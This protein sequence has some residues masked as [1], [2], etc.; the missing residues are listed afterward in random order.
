MRELLGTAIEFCS[1]YQT[2][3]DLMYPGC[4]RR[5]SSILTFCFKL[6]LQERISIF[7]IYIYTW[8][9]CSRVSHQRRIHLA[10]KGWSVFQNVLYFLRISQRRKCIF[11][12]RL[13]ISIMYL[14]HNV[15]IESE[16]FFGKEQ[17]TVE[18]SRNLLKMSIL[19]IWNTLSGLAFDF[20]PRL[21]SSGPSHHR[22][23]TCRHANRCRGNCPPRSR[24]HVSETGT[25]TWYVA[26]NN[27]VP[28]G[29]VTCGVRTG[30]HQ[31][32]SPDSCPWRLRLLSCQSQTNQLTN[33]EMS[34][35]NRLSLTAYEAYDYEHRAMAGKW[36]VML[37][38][39]R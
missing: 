6:S 34:N 18:R 25:T 11:T 13:N 32:S 15:C 21:N 36:G 26:C 3:D 33:P 27:P 20:E 14:N 30:H 39:F 23:S 2:F 1:A 22:F 12:C 24:S 5:S 35:V 9:K 17:G 19:I 29:T 4:L 37:Q 7:W 16:H 31:I 8:Y 38:L 28:A 10:L